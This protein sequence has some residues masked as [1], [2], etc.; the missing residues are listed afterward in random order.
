[1]GRYSACNLSKLEI[2]E[3]VRVNQ[4]FDE[5]QQIVREVGCVICEPPAEIAPAEAKLYEI[6]EHIGAKNSVH[7]TTAALIA[8]KLA[9]GV[10]ALV[11]DVKTGKNAFTSSF[12][13]AK[14]LATKISAVSRACNM[15]TSAFISDM[16]QPLSSSIGP[17]LE[18]REAIAFL[19]N[20]KRH[21]RMFDFV[22]HVSIRSSH[23]RSNQQ[24]TIIS[25]T[26]S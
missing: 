24:R 6:R 14:K 20:N 15:K 13:T 23:D 5:I 9:I 8:Q 19:T 12:N 26:A 22:E 4:S 25:Y 16:G 3:G 7:L 10:E 1:M 18:L 11:F 21:R 17:G 2:V